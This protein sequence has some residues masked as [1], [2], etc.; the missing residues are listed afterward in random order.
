[1]SRLVVVGSTNKVKIEA[2]KKALTPYGYEVRGEAVESFVSNQPLS[3]EETIKGAHN[4]ASNCSSGNL[5]IGLEAGVALIQDK[6][7]LTNYGVL[8]SSNGKEYMAGGARIPLPDVI[9]DLII[10]Q[11]MELAN[12]MDFYFKTEDIKHNEGAIGYFT[13]NV[14]KRVDLFVH[15]VKLLYGQYLMGGSE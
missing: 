10:N 6:L 11:G 15:I 5:K 2:V 14:V 7:F 1:M 12:A 8:I 4:R 13:S 9:K 3:D